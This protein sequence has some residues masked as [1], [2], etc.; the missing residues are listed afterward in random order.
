MSKPNKKFGD[1][2]VRIRPYHVKDAPWILTISQISIEM[3]P[4]LFAIQPVQGE[5]ISLDEGEMFDPYAPKPL[6]KGVPP[7]KPAF[8]LWFREFGS[9]RNF[10]LNKTN[11]RALIAAFGR[12]PQNAKGKL[13]VLKYGKTRQ[14][15]DT[16]L[17]D[18]APAGSKPGVGAYDAPPQDEP[19]PD[20]T[21]VPLDE[22]TRHDN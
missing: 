17:L 4:D 5:V 18:I 19:A 20:E 10:L 2:E 16:I 12:E 21:P 13:V 22:L 15:K 9:R 14:G 1:L 8:V 3:I 6:K 11:E 7:M